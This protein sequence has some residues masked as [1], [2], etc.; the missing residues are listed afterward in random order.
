MKIGFLDNSFTNYHMKKFLGLLRGDAGKDKVVVELGWEL[1]PTDEGK[2]WCAENGL[3]YCASAEEVIEKSDAIIALAP[4]NPEKHLELAGEALLSGKPVFL[5][6]ML[7]QSPEHAREI[8]KLAREH[9][10]PLMSSSGLRFAK[11]LDA[12]TA[13]LDGPVN[14][15]FARGLGK[16]PIYAIHT[17]TMALRFFGG[18]VRR[19]IDTGAEGARL[20]SLDGGGSRRA[21][22]DVRESENAYETT[23]WQVGVLIGGKYEVA[24]VADFDG[25]YANLMVHALK[26]LETGESPM[27]HEE[28]L[29]NVVVQAAAEQSFA[30][31]GTWV[32]TQALV[33]M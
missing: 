15:V 26:F 28:M 20:L 21:T 14:T 31:G 13:K 25:F 6:K 24:T 27:S 33:A 11:E 8:L 16:F 3:K 30:A 4:N 5:D 7:A 19:V 22:V 2:A 32:E 29:A 10:T 18:D 1:T 23:P 12:I 17:I 9:N